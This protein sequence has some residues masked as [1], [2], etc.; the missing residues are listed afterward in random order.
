MKKLI[1]PVIA[2]IVVVVASNFLVNI[3]INDWLTWGA[4]TYPVSFLI[5]EMTNRVYGPKAARQVVYIGFACAVVVSAYL[6]SPRIAFASGAAFFIGQLMDVYMFH[7]LR[8]LAWWKP[9][10]VSSTIGSFIDTCVFFSLAFAGTD[11]PWV[12][13]GMGDFGIKLV[14][15]LLFLAPFRVFIAFIARR[16]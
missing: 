10:F 9:P 5:N 11:M 13:L 6:V 4:L 14:L 7:L 12:T 15:S 1:L 8:R 2:M 16:T 3:V